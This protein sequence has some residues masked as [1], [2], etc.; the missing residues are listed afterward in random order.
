MNRSH[1]QGFTLAELLVVISI[2]VLLVAILMPSLNSVYAVARQT[3][4]QNNL[5]HLRVGL[6]S[7][8]A[9]DKLAKT[10]KL[11]VTAWRS[12][13]SPYLSDS[14][15]VMICP[16]GFTKQ[17]SDDILAK[18]AIRTLN[19]SNFLYNMPLS[20]GPACLK[21]NVTN[22]GYTYD[23]AFE[24][25]RTASGEASGDKDFN[26]VILHI[27]IQGENATITL[28]SSS[29]GY[30]WYLVDPDDKVLVPDMFKSGPGVGH[31][32]N[33]TG[34]NSTFSYGLNSVTPS[35]DPSDP[36][37]MLMDYP[38]D[39]IRI[40]GLDETHDNW[41]KWLGSDG[42]YTFARHRGRCNVAM[43]DGSVK[44]MWPRDIDP[45]V[46]DLK[47]KYYNP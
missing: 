12:Q 6:A 39:V 31:S 25:I 15:D 26:D 44:I 22:G 9:K 27:E 14:N 41:L 34:V 4:C 38:N 18:Y 16:E 37:I 40:V 11:S 29:G 20:A 21:Q 5:G 3:I 47:D 36:K 7:L 30:H 2:I 13:I 45:S 10:G 1:R 28:K 43:A 32:V 33:V 17:F 8:E 23:L 24:D 35:L 42:R 19:G 46:A